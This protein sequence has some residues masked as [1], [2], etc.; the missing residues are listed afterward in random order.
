MSITTILKERKEKIKH[1]REDALKEAKRLSSLLRG[2]YEFESLYL[3]GSILTDR[4]G[5]H[6]DIDIVIKGLRVQD[7]FKAYAF[8]I[9]EGKY[10]IDLKPFEELT[11]DFKK[12]VLTGGIK[13][14]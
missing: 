5:F 14:G 7:F 2:H 10:E 6:S 1:L 8:L 3:C 9:K 13:I 12:K 4:F 11:G